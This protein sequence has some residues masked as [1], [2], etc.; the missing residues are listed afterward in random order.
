M[1]KERVKHA[2][3]RAAAT[4]DNNAYVQKIASAKLVHLTQTLPI[5]QRILEIG[6]GTGY[7]T[8]SLLSAY[9]QTP[10]LA[11][12]ISEEMVEYCKKNFFNKSS[13]VEFKA[14]DGEKINFSFSPDWIVSNFAFQ[15]FEEQIESIKNLYKNSQYLIFTT[16]LSGTFEEWKK[17]CEEFH[18]PDKVLSFVSE[19]EFLANMRLLNP[20]YL[21]IQT[22]KEFYPTPLAF[23]SSLRKIG[24][25]ETRGNDK[26]VNIKNMKRLLEKKEPLEVS[27][28][29][30]YCILKNNI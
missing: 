9:P 3:G 14:E 22:E 15:W 18:L 10:Y 25:H 27:Y 1:D 8:S 11:T 4:Y 19:S 16:L 20:Q 30:A 7:L 12:D 29:V 21:S 24:A 17:V 6:C 13:M 23:L 2:F 26:A 28:R 5:P